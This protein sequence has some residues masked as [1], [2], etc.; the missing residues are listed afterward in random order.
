MRQEQGFCV[1]ANGGVAIASH[2]KSARARKTVT[3]TVTTDKARWGGSTVSDRREWLDEWCPRCWWRLA[4]AAKKVAIRLGSGR[5][6]G[7]L[8]TS[9]RSRDP[10]GIATAFAGHRWIRAPVTRMVADRCFLIAGQRG[11]E[12]FERPFV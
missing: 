1:P 8:V 10:C 11:G 4:V 6:H 7:A 5:V 9:S 3:K 12:P 2:R